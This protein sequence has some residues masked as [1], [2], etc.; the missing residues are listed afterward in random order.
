MLTYP[1]LHCFQERRWEVNHKA[2]LYLYKLSPRQPLMHGRQNCHLQTP[3]Y[4]TTLRVGMGT[5]MDNANQLLQWV[6]GC[7][8]W[9]WPGTR[10]SNQ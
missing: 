5:S 2:P 1:R 10:G 9:G 6:P 3:N 4:H 7:K 8:G